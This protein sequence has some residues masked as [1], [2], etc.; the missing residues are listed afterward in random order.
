MRSLS[1]VYITQFI[2]G[3][4]WDGFCNCETILFI[5]SGPIHFLAL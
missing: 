2:K 1:N 4:K 5:K 3:V